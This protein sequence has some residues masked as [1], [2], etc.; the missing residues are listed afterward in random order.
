MKIEKN[1]LISRI[2]YQEVL[3]FLF[4]LFDKIFCVEYP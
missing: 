2:N 1:D 4:L 3:F